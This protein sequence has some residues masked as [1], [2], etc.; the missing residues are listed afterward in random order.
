MTICLA[1]DAFSVKV[2]RFNKMLTSILA[3]F[4][5]LGTANKSHFYDPCSYFLCYLTNNIVVNESQ[6][7]SGS[8]A[9]DYAVGRRAIVVNPS[10]NHSKYFCK[11]SDSESICF[12]RNEFSICISQRK[13]FLFG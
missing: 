2:K 13:V 7:L 10:D 12:A 11:A 8:K 4:F 6:L 3:L 5:L 9:V 1:D